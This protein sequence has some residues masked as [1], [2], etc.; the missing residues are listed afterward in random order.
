MS[1]KYLVHEVQRELATLKR[2]EQTATI[3]RLAEKRYE[4]LVK[5]NLKEIEEYA[6]LVVRTPNDDDSACFLSK[7]RDCENAALRYQKALYEVKQKICM[8]AAIHQLHSRRLSAL[9]KQQRE[10]V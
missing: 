5:A 4:N 10:A 6:K 7:K 1:K 9:E 3:L 2:I 8:N